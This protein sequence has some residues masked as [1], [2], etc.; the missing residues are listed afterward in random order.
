MKKLKNITIVVWAKIIILSFT[1]VLNSAAQ[2]GLLNEV[3]LLSDCHFAGPLQTVSLH[4]AV[5]QWIWG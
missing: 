4:L 3:G 2:L 5:V 1:I